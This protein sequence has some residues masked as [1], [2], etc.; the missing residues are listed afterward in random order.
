MGEAVV[1][2]DFVVFMS[3]GTLFHETTER[4]VDGWNVEAAT[5]MARGITERHGATPFGFYFI[6]RSRGPNDLDSKVSKKSGRYY[7]GGT[8]RTADEVL[9][10]TDPSEEILRSNVRANRIKRI[11]VNDNSWRFTTGLNDDDTVLDF[12]PSK[13]EQS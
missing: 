9:A 4:E 6:T 3:P 7:L 13:A 1:S 11:L 8:I 12:T 5:N 10:G 2:K